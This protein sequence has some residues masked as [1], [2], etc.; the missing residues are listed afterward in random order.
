MKRLNK[1]MIGIFV[2]LVILA[3]Q[4][5][6]NRPKLSHENTIRYI[7]SAYV[8]IKKGN[9]TQADSIFKKLLM[10]QLSPSDSIYMSMGYVP[11]LLNKNDTRD[12]L[13]HIDRAFP[14]NNTD[15]NNLLR[16]YSYRLTAFMIDKNCI[17]ARHELDLMFNLIG[18]DSTMS[19]SKADLIY[20]RTV[21]N[22]MC[23][24]S[25]ASL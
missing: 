9:Y 3:C 22:R 14:K 15:R 19:L 7:D 8:F 10:Y 11:V 4:H 6:N 20:N 12:A 25:G 21:L 13:I 1:F 23:A 24:S 16:R 18:N 17:K 2:M 5:D